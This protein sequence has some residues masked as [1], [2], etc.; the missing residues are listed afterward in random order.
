MHLIPDRPDVIAQFGERQGFA[1]LRAPLLPQGI[2]EL[3][4]ITSFTRFTDSMPFAGKHL[5]LCFRLNR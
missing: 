4:N 1:C 5:F 2:V 3:L